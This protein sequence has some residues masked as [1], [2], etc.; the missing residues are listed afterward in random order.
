MIDLS[1]C[2][3]TFR[4][5]K[6]L[7]EC[8]ISLYENTRLNCEFIVVD[9]GSM[10]GTVEMLHQEF[11]EVICIENDS[12]LGFTRPMNQ[13]LKI[14]TGRYLLLL[15]P[16][17]LILPDALDILV[18]F[19][20]AHPEVGICGPKVLNSDYS[21]QKQCRRGESTPWAVITYFTGLADLF[22][23]SKLFG[24]YL[25]SYMDEDKTHPVAGVAGSCMLVRR[26]VVNDIG[27]LD[28]RFFAYQE[29]ADYCYRA[30]NAGWKVFYVPEAKI[31]HYGGLGGSRV[32]PY[33]SIFEWHR[34]Y[35]LYYRKNLAENYLFI[36][37]WIYYAA[38]LFKL[39]SAMVI[40]VFRKDK[41]VG[42]RKP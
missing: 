11:P 24:Q 40:N 30:H 28:E 39:V 9:N 37:N 36:F 3:V 17:T 16:D 29:D 25:M 2:I 23:D 42:S 10:D 8:L 38:M 22:P 27:Y 20:E 21:L 35:F 15:N 32:Q 5:R 13:A 33:R 34:S 14:A 7:Q 12:N 31:I 19:L 1:V 41:V 26:E 4:A 6:L 18:K